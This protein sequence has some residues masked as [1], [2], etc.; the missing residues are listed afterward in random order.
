MMHNLCKY[1]IPKCAQR[2]TIFSSSIRS[3]RYLPS[4]WSGVAV[5]C[6]FNHRQSS[7]SSHATVR[8]TNFKCNKLDFSSSSSSNN[9]RIVS[10]KEV[11]FAYELAPPLLDSA[12][13]TVRRGM[14]VTIMGQNGSGKSTIF[15]LLNKELE[16]ISGAITLE[17]GLT[18]ALASQV[19]PVCWLT[20]TFISEHAPT[21]YGH[22]SSRILSSSL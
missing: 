9:N 19:A 17:T 16:S 4:I 13:F 20:V 22:D 8:D 1:I 11:T 5:N 12:S 15:K 6:V 21:F 7:A 10:F 2:R 18:V 14:K 3:G